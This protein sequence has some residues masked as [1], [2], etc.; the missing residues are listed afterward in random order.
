MSTFFVLSAAIALRNPF[1]PIGYDGEREVISAEPRVAVKVAST[2][3]VETTAADAAAALEPEESDPVATIARHWAAARSSL[4]IG[5]I[6]QITQEDGSRRQS[7]TI[8]GRIYGNDD[9]I[10]VNHDSRRFT[11]RIKEL[12]EGKTLKLVRVRVRDLDDDSDP[13]DNSKGNNP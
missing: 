9:V 2:N 3:E 1:W 8:N 6:T 13:D 10:S 12:T 5:G 7:I 11:W 4:R